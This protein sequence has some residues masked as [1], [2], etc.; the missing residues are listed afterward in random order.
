MLAHV[1]AHPLASGV[2]P[3]CPTP[4]AF[5]AWALSAEDGKHN[6]PLP[7]LRRLGLQDHV[8]SRSMD[9]D[10]SMVIV[11]T[12]AGD[13]S[14]LEREQI[15]EAWIAPT[16]DQPDQ[17]LPFAAGGLDVVKPSRI[18]MAVARSTASCWR[19]SIIALL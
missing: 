3:T 11:L 4:V 7:C 2:P 15:I 19:L 18:T 10:F 1:A 5:P 12:L 17:L 13:T 16:L 14:T 8:C 6:P 9:T